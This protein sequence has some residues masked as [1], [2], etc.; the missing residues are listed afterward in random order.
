MTEYWKSLNEPS[1]EQD[2]FPE[3]L[4]IGSHGF[5]RR[6]F[7]KAAGFS[8]AGA[9]LAGCSRAPVEKAIPHLNKPE[10]ITPGVAY[11]YASTCGACSAGCGLL[12]KVRD[13]RPV[14]L[15]GNPQHALSRG[16]L[17]AVGQA[18]ILGLY[19]S[20]RLKSPLRGGTQAGWEEVDREITAELD[21]FRR[22][23]KAVRFLSP[24]ILSPTLRHMIDRFLQGFPGARH[25]VYDPLSCSAILDAHQAT[26]GARVLPHY[27]FE[28]AEVI[29]G[30]DAD[31]LGTWISPVEFTAGY[32]AG[33][34]L[35]GE[36]ARFSYHIQFEPRLSITGSKADRRIRV[37]PSELETVVAHLA[38]LIA[39][40]AGAA[41]DLGPLGPPPAPLE[42]LADRLWNARGRSLVVSGSQDVT[43]QVLVNY[44]NHT[45]GNY[46]ATLDLDRPS[47]QRQG[48]DRQLEGLI[49]ELREGQVAALFVYGVNPVYD[50]PDGEAL[51]RAIQKVPLAVSFAERLDE[52]ASVSRYVCPDHH[53]LESWGDAEPVSG[54]LSLTQPVIRPL[55][56][57]RSVLES[58]AAWQGIRKSA[59]DLSRES[60][61]ASVF[62]RQTQEKSFQT[63]SDKAVHDGCVEV[64]P[65]RT[66]IR[67]FSMVAVE[68]KPPARAAFELV[69]YPKAGMLDGR[70]A[71]NPWLQELPDPITKVTWD[72]YA[73]LSPT[74][75][76]NLGVSDG[77]VV[78]L[79]ARGKTLELPALIQPGQHDRVVA[80]A[81][82]YGRKET[83]RFAKIGPAW[84]HRRL[85]VGEDGYV[86]KA[87]SPLLAFSGSTLRYSAVCDK[88]GKT[89]RR[90]ELAAT[91]HHHNIHVPKE[92]GGERRPVIEE[93][94]LEEA[95]RRGPETGHA[96]D[97]WPPDHA[98]PGQRWGMAIDLTACTGCSACVIACQVENNVP[99]VGKDEVRRQR[100]MHW[101]RLDRYY[102]GEGDSLT[103][104]H[105]PMLCQHCEHAPCETVCPVLATV[106]SADGLNQ[107]V[108]NRCVGTRYCAN[109]CPYKVRRFNWFDY[110]HEDKL[111]NMVLNPDVT[112]R[113]RGVMEKCSFCIQRIQEARIEA[114]RRGEE[115]E[116]GDIRTACQQTC[117]A[118]A[119]V[120]GDMNDPESRISKLLESPRRYHVLEDLNVLPSIGYLALVR[121]RDT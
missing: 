13:G 24:A 85:S 77:D 34:S 48:N 15:E 84:L 71:Y 91:Q 111:Q 47:A 103:V 44:L 45:L 100:E 36:P 19:D 50:L 79:E 25:V 29:A 65:A 110:P 115:I 28:R 30:F 60:W 18:S 80:I 72:N 104:A 8:F 1:S 32:A 95:R 17:C 52:T 49:G 51:A 114:R 5:G 64:A 56:D 70:H 41:L 98:V 99:V 16:A 33:R 7:L 87:A 59:Y 42:P 76:A 121:N 43:T 117:P 102:S 116:D 9:M 38:A 21:A 3:L 73:C 107:Q 22:D 46:G 93:R 11:H 40:K 89:G 31:F 58:L 94:T 106:H 14:K 10:E 12:V 6:G 63:W 90:Q 118:G 39:M 27:R 53:Y 86:G 37:A 54:V 62:P 101:I 83:Q 2:E 81:L 105:Q 69:L 113:S 68:R 88:I 108:Y 23:R 61:Q 57:T 74:A 120:F 119:I 26:H 67:P 78:R 112:V 92:L 66:A 55:G 35:E 82:G 75:A 20:L 96:A 97:L 4:Q 109:N